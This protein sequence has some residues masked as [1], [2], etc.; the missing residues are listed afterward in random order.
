MNWLKPIHAGQV[1]EHSNKSIYP[2]PYAL[3]MNGR[4]KRKLG[5]FFYLTNF[6][7]NLTE[8]SPGAMSA[9]KHKHSL[10]DELIYILS[11][12]PTL[13]YGSNEYL[14]R[15]GECF[16]FKAGDGNAHHLVNRSE[17]TV[18]YIEIGDRTPADE[19]EYPDDDLC[20]RSEMDG[21]WVFTHKDG[22]PY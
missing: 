11:G 2:E 18:L 20:A 19:V 7:V 8:L 3:L 5:D 21:A 14:M 4:I 9:L 22:R 1:P 12:T 17:N 10:Q 15:A 13:I 6:G 16:G